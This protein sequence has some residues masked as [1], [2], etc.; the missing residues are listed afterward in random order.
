MGTE[1]GRAT[2][3]IVNASPARVARWCGRGSGRDELGE[4]VKNGQDHAA[5][6][7]VGAACALSRLIPDKVPYRKSLLRTVLG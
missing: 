2:G 6:R 3:I 7:V 1:S 5:A 4:A